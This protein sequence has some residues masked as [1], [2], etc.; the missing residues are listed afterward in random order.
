MPEP[1]ACPITLTAADR[2]RLKERAAGRKTP[3][4]DRQRALIVLLAA[5][6][7][8]TAV[9][10]ARVG[11]NVDTARKWRTRFASQGI[12]GLTDLPRSGRP[13]RFT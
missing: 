6:G 8:A 10:A 7:H 1:R 2:R 5:R 3:F 12:A 11:V 13:R 4:R 9:V